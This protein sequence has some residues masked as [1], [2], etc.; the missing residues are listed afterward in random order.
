MALEILGE[1]LCGIRFVNANVR[2]VAVCVKA[3]CVRGDDASLSGRCKGSD[4]HRVMA[5]AGS[6]EEKRSGVQNRGPLAVDHEKGSLLPRHR[7]YENVKYALHSLADSLRSKRCVYELIAIRE[8]LWIVMRG[9][10]LR[11]V[12]LRDRPDFPAALVDR[13]DS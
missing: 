1:D 5:I 9:L 11:A 6:P 2:T 10:A 4:V 7:G 12:D 3:W 13:E 8:K